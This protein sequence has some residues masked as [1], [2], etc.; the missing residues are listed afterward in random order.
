M[1]RKAYILTFDRDDEVNYKD[2]HNKLTTLPSV[3][4]WWHY[5]K[6]SYILISNSPS[7]TQLSDKIRPLFPD[8]KIFLL[9]E[10]NLK[11][12]NGLL[13]KEAWDWLRIESTKI[14]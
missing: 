14:T 2:F 5:I 4:N 11:N 10:L 3:F 6:S 9:I 12:R 8:G 1:A 13:I 7:A